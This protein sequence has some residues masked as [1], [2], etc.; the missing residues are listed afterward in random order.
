VLLIA[1]EV[2]TGF[3]RVSAWFAS[4]RYGIDADLMVCAK[5]LTSRYLPA[6]AVLAGARVIE[7]FWSEDAGVFRHGYTYSGHPTACAVALA[8]LDGL[9]GEH[10]VDRVRDVEAHFAA[11]IGALDAHPLVGAVRAEGLMAGME[12]APR[13][14][15]AIPRPDR[16]GRRRRARSRR[17]D[18]SAGRTHT[19]AVAAARDHD[20]RDDAARRAPGEPSTRSSAGLT[21]STALT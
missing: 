4:T 9:E 8:N 10:L 1:D 20:G 15:R 17:A 14:S 7:C 21:V 16:P 5:G 11:T 19:A 18:L 12:L 2:V 13:R 3:G 6:G